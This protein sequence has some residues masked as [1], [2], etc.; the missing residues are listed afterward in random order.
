[1]I[2]KLQAIEDRY[3][4]LENSI[5]DPSAMQDMDLWQKNSKTLS[6]LSGIVTKFRE[7]KLVQQALNDTRELTK[8]SDPELRAMA[9]AEFD[10][11]RDKNAILEEELRVLLLPKDPNDEKNVIVEIRGGAGGDEAALFAGDLFRMYSRFAETQGWRTE[12]LDSSPTGLGGF[13]EVVFLIEGD[14]VYS[15]LKFESGVHRVQ[16]VPATEASGRI[17]TSTVTVAV[18]AEAEDVDVQINPTIYGLIR[19]V[20]VVQADSTSTKRNPLCE[21]PIYRQVLSYSVRTKSRN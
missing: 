15:K 12:M 6:K 10:D 9:F 19:T 1:M 5:S 11:L 21:S 17:H 20:P 2:N 13:K 4:E 14:G 18:L 16:R 3:M 7:Y 8:E